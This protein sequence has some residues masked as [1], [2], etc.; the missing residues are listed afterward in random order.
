MDASCTGLIG[1]EYEGLGVVTQTAT[2]HVSADFSPWAKDPDVLIRW[3][4]SPQAGV[5][6]VM[7]PMGPERW[8]PDSEEWV[9]HL[10]Y[11][12]DCAETDAQVEAD[13]R[14]ALGI[15][16]LPMKIHKI[17][18]WS[19]EAVIASAFRAGRVF[20]LGDAA[21]RHPPT[22]GLGLTSAIHDAQ[23]LCW[24]L[25]A[26][27]AG[28]AS[29]ALLD[30]YEAERRPVDQRNCQ[31]SLENAINHFQTGA[32]TRRLPGE[33]P[34]GEH[35]AAAPGVE[36]PARRRRAPREPCCAGCARSRWS[37]PS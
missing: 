26:V 25:A 14:T 29:P 37:S 20:L 8:G 36:R 5:L 9:I 10:N 31:R 21:H 3:I 19:V 12:V 27:L 11:P 1:V 28:H 15:G 32:A 23:N 34:G 2:L 35:G 18:R 17:T 22:G 13:A 33:P 16:E 4:Y 6:V 30:T 7:V 24:K